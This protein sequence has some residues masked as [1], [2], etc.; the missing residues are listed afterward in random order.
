MLTYCVVVCVCIHA[1]TP[2]TQA[3]IERDPSQVGVTVPRDFGWNSRL[4][5]TRPSSAVSVNLQL[6]A[7]A[8]ALSVHPS[9]CPSLSMELNPSLTTKKKWGL[10]LCVLRLRHRA[11]RNR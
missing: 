6:R 9:V 4:G 2:Q 7:G 10:A 8:A 1:Y 3:V 11:L 5:S